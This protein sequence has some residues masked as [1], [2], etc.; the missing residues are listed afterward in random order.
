[1][2]FSGEWSVIPAQ[3]NA[4]T[5]QV[6]EYVGLPLNESALRR[7]EIWDPAIESLPIWQ[8]R[9][10]SG[11]AIKHGPSNLRMTQQ[12]EPASRELVAFQAE[13]LRSGNVPIYM[14]GRAHPPAFASHTWGGYS[15]G[16]WRGPVL[17]IRTT[18]LKEGLYRR[19][20][21]PQSD[22]ATLMEYVI[23]RRFRDQDYLTWVV[24]A[25]D[26]VYLTEPLIRSSEY[27]QEP[28]RRLTPYPC[29]VIRPVNG[30]GDGVPS[31]IP[32]TN[33]QLANFTSSY[34]LPPRVSADGAA[35]M[36]PEYRAM[37]ADWRVRNPTPVRNV[38]AGG[39]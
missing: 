19:N 14:D 38:P 32:G 34:G 29:A 20:G 6:G 30:S 21:V 12:V 15:T 5:P 8:C 17:E 13:W 2:D 31:F 7:A 28:T 24:I 4:D 27:R 35:T 18:H 39:F 9:P 23:R 37:L 3:S 33:N 16:R 22:R 25:D 36:Y 10:P 26:P 1:M 11:A